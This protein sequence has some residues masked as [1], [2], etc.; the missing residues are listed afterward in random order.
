MRNYRA[1]FEELVEQ[2]L[3]AAIAREEAGS[4]DTGV[5]DR[6]ATRGGAR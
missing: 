2:D 3:D 6:T 5:S 1:L 4:A